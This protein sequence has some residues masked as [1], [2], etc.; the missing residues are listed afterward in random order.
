MPQIDMTDVEEGF[1]VVDEGPYRL[2]VVGH[3]EKQKEGS[4]YAYYNW[5]L[6][7]C[8]GDKV[9]H[10]VFHMTSLSPK[11]SGMLKAFLRACGVDVS[12][13]VDFE[14]E[15]LYSREFWAILKIAKYL[16]EGGNPDNEED[17][18]KSNKI[19]SFPKDAAA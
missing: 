1:P 18:R 9:G 12:G 14:P 13:V 15:D 8:E 3:E 4:D 17:W 11:A 16:P 10:T 7:V 2:T 19:K 5:K 6:E